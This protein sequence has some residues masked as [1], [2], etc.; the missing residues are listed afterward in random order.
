V[1]DF[2][3]EF[4]GG[5]VHVAFELLE[6]NWLLAEHENG[7]DIED[8]DILAVNSQFSEQ[9]LVRR[10]TSHLFHLRFGGLSG[11]LRGL[12]GV[13]LSGVKNTALVRGRSGK[14]LWPYG[15]H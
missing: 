14:H 1:G 4:C 6:G 2:D 7:R 8:G 5:V 13:Q 9:E 12:V 11:A 3:E 10:R 15:Y